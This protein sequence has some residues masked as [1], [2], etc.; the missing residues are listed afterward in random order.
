MYF[1]FPVVGTDSCSGDVQSC[2]RQIKIFQ[3]DRFPNFLSYTRI[4]LYYKEDEIH[5]I[6]VIF[7][8]MLKL[9]VKQSVT[10]DSLVLFQFQW[11]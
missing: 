8:Q 3:M 7:K 11:L 6:T 5:K 4:G 2:D 10:S 9:G 1:G